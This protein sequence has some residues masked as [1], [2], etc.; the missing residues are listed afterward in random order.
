MDSI[1]NDEDTSYGGVVRADTTGGPL[2]SSSTFAIG[3]GLILF[4]LLIHFTHSLVMKI[5]S[6]TTF[7]S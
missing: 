1:G 2:A 3:F 7:Y 5:R 6:D 4:L